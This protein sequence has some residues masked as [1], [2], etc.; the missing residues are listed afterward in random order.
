LFIFFAYQKKRQPIT[1]RFTADPFL[2]DV[3]ALFETTWRCE[4]R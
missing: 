3:P 2:A 1:R 4:T